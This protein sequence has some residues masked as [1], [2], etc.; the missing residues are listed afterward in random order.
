MI[1]PMTDSK[2]PDLGRADVIPGF[3][4]SKPTFKS[5]FDAEK[6][7]VTRFM[8]EYANILSGLPENLVREGLMIGF[9]EVKYCGLR[10]GAP[11]NL[12]WMKSTGMLPFLTWLSIKVK[13]PQVT[14]E[15]TCQLFVDY[16]PDEI[17]MATWQL[18]GLIFPEDQAVLHTDTDAPA[19]AV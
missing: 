7:V 17:A 13:H 10:E 4:L 8:S 16:N 19:P 2:T 6:E 18:W 12:V 3:I 14:L 1:E 15:Q 9:Q 11:A 5:R